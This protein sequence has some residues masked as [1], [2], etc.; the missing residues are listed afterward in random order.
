MLDSPYARAAYPPLD[1]W[2]RPLSVTV[3]A[4]TPSADAL[5]KAFVA[6]VGKQGVKI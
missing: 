6:A 3:N 5:A 1:G 2:S 4:V